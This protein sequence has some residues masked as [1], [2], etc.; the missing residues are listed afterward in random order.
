MCC[1]LCLRHYSLHC[2]AS[3]PPPVIQN[4]NLEP[5]HTSSPPPTTSHYSVI[6]MVDKVQMTVSQP[7]LYIQT[8]KSAEA[9][10]TL[11]LF[12]QLVLGGPQSS[13]GSG[14]EIKGLASSKLKEHYH[15]STETKGFDIIIFMIHIVSLFWRCSGSA[16]N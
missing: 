11:W 14:E 8:L 10:I 3:P 7:H 1:D 6:L 2:P 16:L 13:Q 4:H 15:K 5:R 12:E 9:N